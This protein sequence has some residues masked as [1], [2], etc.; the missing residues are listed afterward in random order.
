MRSGPSRYR[1]ALLAALCAA[2]VLA[3]KGEPDPTPYCSDEAAVPAPLTS[4]QLTYQRDVKPIF[5]AICTY[6]H[7]PGGS[8]PFPLETYEQALASR[9]AIAE[10]VE[11]RRMPPWLAARCCRDYHRD[12]SLTDEQVARITGWA[13][14]GGAEGNP[15]DAVTGTPIFIGLSRVDLTLEMPEPYTPAPR[16]GGTDDVRCFVLD[17]PL[18]EPRYVTGLNPLPGTRSVVHHLVV[19]VLEGDEVASAERADRAD[20]GPGFDC[21]GGLGGLRQVRPIGGSLIGGDFPADLGQRIDP[22]SKILLNI[23]YTTLRGAIAD[24]TSIEF[25]LDDA[26]RPARTIVIANPAWLVRGAMRVRAGDPDAVFWYHYEPLLFTRGKPVQL[27]GVT[28]HMHYF[29]SRMTVRIWRASGER[30]CLLE[31]PSWHFG[32]EQPFWFAA[33]VTLAPGDELYLECHFD[34]SAANQ[35]VPGMQPRDFSWGGNNQDMCA[36][37]VAFTEAS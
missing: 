25:R 16:A 3:C 26:A 2:S 11:S 14:Q 24:R 36:A 10:A 18:D 20:P 1:A 23:H 28:P 32:A 7:R 5:D 34:N 21:S 33:P 12:W 9:D 4:D 27:W 17:W 22:G 15:A 13:A 29:A 8:A 35:P 19:A 37:F 30:D 31:I 6:C